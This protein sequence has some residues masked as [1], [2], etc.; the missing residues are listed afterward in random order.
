MN[1]QNTLV[2]KVGDSMVVIDLDELIYF[3]C[4]GD[5]IY[6]YFKNSKNDFEVGD[7]KLMPALLEAMSEKFK[8]V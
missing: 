5:T 1:A 3:H 4:D 8:N 6:L 7:R 2:V